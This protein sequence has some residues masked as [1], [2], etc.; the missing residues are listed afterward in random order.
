MKL[1]VNEAS[2]RLM[3]LLEYVTFTGQYCSCT[4][5]A[6]LYMYMY[7][8]DEDLKLNSELFNWPAKMDPIF[9]VSLSR[10]V[11]KREQAENDTKTKRD[12]FKRTL[13]EYEE[14]IESFREKEVQNCMYM[15]INSS[16]HV[17]NRFQTIL[18]ELEVL[19]N[20]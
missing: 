1:E 9:E 20:N 16:L 17:L 2:K 11:S 4:I 10:V 12:E 3:Y 7:W 15:Y 18:M 14:E 5:L 8:T 19:L 13:E 6:C